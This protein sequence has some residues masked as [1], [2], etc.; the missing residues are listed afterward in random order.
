MEIGCHGQFSYPK[1]SNVLANSALSIRFNNG[2]SLNVETNN[3]VRI[4]FC[5]TLK[6]AEYQNSFGK[7]S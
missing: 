4:N 7:P 1:A 3:T 6:N 2:S 5:E